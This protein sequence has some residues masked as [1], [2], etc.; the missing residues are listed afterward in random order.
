MKWNTKRNETHPHVIPDEW[1]A[2]FTWNIWPQWYGKYFFYICMNKSHVN[3]FMLLSSFKTIR[4]PHTPHILPEICFQ[5]R[6][7]T[8]I[9]NT[10]L[11][12]HDNKMFIFNRENENRKENWK[13]CV[14]INALKH[15]KFSIC[16]QMPLT[17]P[18][19]KAMSESGVC[20]NCYLRDAVLTPQDPSTPIWK[21]VKMCKMKGLRHLHP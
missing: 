12:P 6:K 3:Y 13:Y 18:S 8:N 17:D 9:N 19:R 21:T 1:L 11:E 15:L 5:R 14:K 7:K 16:S 10:K 2:F 20:E 4:L